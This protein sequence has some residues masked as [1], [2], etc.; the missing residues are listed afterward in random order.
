[1]A[2]NIIFHIIGVNALLAAMMRLRRD[3]MWI[4]GDDGVEFIVPPVVDSIDYNIVSLTE[5]LEQLEIPCLK[6][7]YVGD[8]PLPLNEEK[9]ASG[10]YVGPKCR[11]AFEN[12]TMKCQE[13]GPSVFPLKLERKI[14]VG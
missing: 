6:I 2:L 11:F 12:A 7:N 13:V 10:E 8:Y 3:N 5:I 14:E 9:I 4:H 1:V